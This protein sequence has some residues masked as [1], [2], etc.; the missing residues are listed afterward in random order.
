MACVGDVMLDRFIY[1]TVGRISPEA[2][3]PVL[4][5]QREAAMPGGAAN[6][7]RNLASL[8]LDVALVG[9]RGHD[10]V[11]EELESAL[12]DVGHVS[13]GLVV[14]SARPTT[15]KARLVAGGQQLLR[16]DAED[17][18]PLSPAEEAALIDRLAPAMT[19]AA[20]LVLSD[21]AKGVLTLSVI[22]AAVGLAQRLGIP[23][24]ADPKH[25][26]FS[27]YGPVDV[28]KPNAA[29]LSAAVGGPAVSDAD[30]EFLLTAAQA[31]FPARSIVVTRA[32]RG[33][34]FIAP[35][36]VVR[37][38]PGKA[39]EVF[40]VSGAGDTSLAALALGLVGGG[41]LGEAVELAVLASG[42]AVGKSGTSTVSSAELANAIEAEAGRPGEGA[43]SQAALA[44]KIT[45]WRAAGLKIGFT[46]G[47]FDILHAG[48]VMLLESARSQCDRLIVGLNSDASVRRLKGASRPINTETARAR[49]LSALAAVDAV[50]IFD[51]DTP[52][53]LITDIQPDVL[54]KGGD[55][56]RET[57]VGADTVEARGGRVIIVPLLEGHSTTRIIARSGGV[58]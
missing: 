52:L 10:Q 4:R 16:M 57:V 54:V 48:H 53:R 45:R 21:Y 39:R 33:M 35:G 29:E 51:E 14:S 18:Q 26:D 46:N 22:A 3:V 5:R 20:A 56:S 27:I 32:A 31:R 9:L 28:L 37:H 41:T 25:R 30:I 19:G 44:E 1:G 47:C 15:L 11:G 36:E 17:T 24:L 49:V 38:V 6:V 42:I 58:I 2:P 43:L 12:S 7:A 50:I 40:D 55:Y 23:V 34:S 8:G 13:A